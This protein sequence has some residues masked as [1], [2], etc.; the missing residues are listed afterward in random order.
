MASPNVG[1]VM[2]SRS[3]PYAQMAPQPMPGTVDRDRYEDVDANPIHQ[4]AA[5]PVSTFSIDVDTASYSNVRR[6]IN[7]GRLPPRDAVRIEELVNYFDYDYPLPRTRAE[8]FSSTI[9]VV[10]SPWAQGRQLL[11]V[12]LQGYNIHAARA[13]AFESRFADRRVGF[14][15]GGKQIAAGAAR[16]SHAGSN[17]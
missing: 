12:G 5:D 6:F 4:V 11:H 16:L 17:S 2:M 7:E 1:G 9:S 13:P 10:P 8:P 3:A 14:D 15:V